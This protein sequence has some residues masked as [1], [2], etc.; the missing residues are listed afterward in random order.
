[1]GKDDDTFLLKS[2]KIIDRI[3][4]DQYERG[5][6]NI[7]DLLP[8]NNS[9]SILNNNKRLEYNKSSLKNTMPIIYNLCKNVFKSEKDIN[10]YI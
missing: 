7:F 8:E 1:M 4:K 3:L 5:K 10:M 6:I 9:N 2:Q